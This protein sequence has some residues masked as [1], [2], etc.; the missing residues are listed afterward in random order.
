MCPE[1]SPKLAS[2][3]KTPIPGLNGG[4]G[5][6]KFVGWI[7]DL[8]DNDTLLRDYIDGWSDWH[9]LDVAESR[10]RS[11]WLMHRMHEASLQLCI[12]CTHV[13]KMCAIVIRTC[14]YTRAGLG[15]Y[16]QN[17]TPI[18]RVYTQMLYNQQLTD[19]EHYIKI[20][21]SARLNSNRSHLRIILIKGI[22][23]W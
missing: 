5:W 15:L 10:K 19:S 4:I 13:Y 11:S 3:S 18:I 16:T 22:T 23:H 17:P 12:W 9:Q 2:N 20:D 14:N 6:S 7:N 1:P 21:L 8:S